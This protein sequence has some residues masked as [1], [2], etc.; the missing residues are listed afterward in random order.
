[1]VILHLFVL[2][3]GDNCIIENDDD[4]IKLLLV[5]IKKISAN[6]TK[7]ELSAIK[8]ISLSIMTIRDRRKTNVSIKIL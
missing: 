1:M 7:D 2:K 6:T 8:D 5:Y 3:V 4:N